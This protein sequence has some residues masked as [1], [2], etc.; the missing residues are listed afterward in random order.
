MPEC[1]KEKISSTLMGYKNKN[2]SSNFIGVGYI[3]TQK[4]YRA[5]IRYNRKSTIIGHFK[6]EIYAAVAYNIKAIELYGEKAIVNNIP[7]W[8]LIDISKKTSSQYTGVSFKRKKQKWEASVWLN[9]KH[10]FVGSYV[11]IRSCKIIQ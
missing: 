7:Q 11:R 8:E 5:T 1:V 9:N 10:Y 2:A 6:D 3:S 4:L